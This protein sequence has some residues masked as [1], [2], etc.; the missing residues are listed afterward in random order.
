MRAPDDVTNHTRCHELG[1]L[2]S[3][4]GSSGT[5]DGV[6][7]IKGALLYVEVVL[8]L[9]VVSVTVPLVW[10]VHTAH[11]GSTCSV[12]TWTAHH[13]SCVAV[14]CIGTSTVTMTACRSMQTMCTSVWMVE[15]RQRGCYMDRATAVMELWL[16]KS[17]RGKSEH[18]NASTMFHVKH[19]QLSMFHVKHQVSLTLKR[20]CWCWH[21]CICRCEFVTLSWG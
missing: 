19:R 2:L 5:L 8:C 4:N 16:C 20:G 12:H 18:N 17:A 7:T 9:A 3:V 13:A 15:L 10:V 1:H 14:R 11:R 21:I 6:G